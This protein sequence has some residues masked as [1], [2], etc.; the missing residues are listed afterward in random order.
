MSKP[1]ATRYVYVYVYTGRKVN[2]ECHQLEIKMLLCPFNCIK[3]IT[4][5]ITKTERYEEKI[6]FM[7]WQQNE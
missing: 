7:L 1:L 4:K 3:S 6:E 5:S 2:V